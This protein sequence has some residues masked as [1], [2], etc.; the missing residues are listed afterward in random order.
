MQHR[1]RLLRQPVCCIF[2]LTS[3]ANADELD[4]ITEEFP[5]CFDDDTN[6]A[7]IGDS[8]SVSSTNYSITGGVIGQLSP[9]YVDD[10]DTANVCKSSVFASA[11]A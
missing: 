8:T 10:T 4:S 1:H 2:W 6:M 11:G 3:T 7:N 5:F 9:E